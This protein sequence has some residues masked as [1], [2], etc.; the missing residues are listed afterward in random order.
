MKDIEKHLH[1]CTS[2]PSPLDHPLT[3]H[4]ES[5]FISIEEG[6]NKVNMQSNKLQDTFD[7]LVFMQKERFKGYQ[8]LISVHNIEIFKIHL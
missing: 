3:P 7:S 5:I 2:I 1:G 8:T 4:H 6:T